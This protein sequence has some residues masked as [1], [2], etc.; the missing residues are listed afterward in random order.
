[1]SAKKILLLG[2]VWLLLLLFSNLTVANTAMVIAPKGSKEVSLFK[3]GHSFTKDLLQPQGLSTARLT[4]E[5]VAKPMP[6][7]YTVLQYDEITRLVLG[8]L[9]TTTA[10]L[11]DTNRCESVSRLLFPYHFF[12]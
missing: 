3:A 12:W 1:M 10:V 2:I 8:F 11:Q 5:Q 6:F 7:G 4:S 9:G